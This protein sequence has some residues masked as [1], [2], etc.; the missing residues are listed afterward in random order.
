M[1]K[2][3]ED[4]D[5][6]YEEQ[7]R[8][9]FHVD[10]KDYNLTELGWKKT[11]GRTKRALGRCRYSSTNG[12]PNGR[13]KSIEVSRA[14]LEMEGQNMDTMR[15]T[16]LHEIAH[17]IDV[18]QRGTSA[19]DSRW[20]AIARQ[21]GADPTRTTDRVESVPGRYTLTCPKCGASTQMH[22]R[23]TKNRACGKCCNKHAGGKYSKEFVFSIE[24]NKTGEIVEPK[25]RR[26]SR[27]SH[28]MNWF[29]I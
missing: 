18:E 27:S 2:H 14:F 5:K 21:V 19:H 22:R 11:Y 13:I 7:M 9:T 26:S 4:F 29:N 6:Y 28:P 3:I 17:A 23:P 25:P 20:K 1:K 24:D 16:V 12:K 15:D 10:G 8:R